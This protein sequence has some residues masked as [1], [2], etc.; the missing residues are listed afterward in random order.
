LCAASTCTAAGSKKIRVNVTGDG[1]ALFPQ[2]DC[3]CPIFSGHAIADV[4][5]GNMT[6]SCEPSEPGKIWSLY[7]VRKDIPQAPEWDPE[8]AAP[9]QVCPKSTPKNKNS[10]QVVNCFSFLCDTETYINRHSPDS[11][12]FGARIVPLTGSGNDKSC[13]VRAKGD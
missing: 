7:S 6:G 3:T 11:R 10:N 13:S 9:P 4:I 1:T 5:G 2:A 12:G 8:T